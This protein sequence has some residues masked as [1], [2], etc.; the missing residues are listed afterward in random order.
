MYPQLSEK[1]TK[2]HIFGQILKYVYLTRYLVSALWGGEGN[3]TVQRLQ[4]SLFFHFTCFFFFDSYMQNPQR[5]SRNGPEFSKHEVILNAQPDK[6]CNN[7]IFKNSDHLSLTLVL[8][9]S[10]P[11]IISHSLGRDQ[12]IQALMQKLGEETKK[13][14]THTRA[15]IQVQ[16]PCL[17]RLTFPLATQH[18]APANDDVDLS[19]TVLH[20]QLYFSQFGFQRSLS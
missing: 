10:V 18:Q 2:I 9:S 14:L 13:E 8:Y 4:H 11:W 6:T 17:R 15:R 20:S 12:V 16:V 3:K 19:G 7:I 1:T 5:H